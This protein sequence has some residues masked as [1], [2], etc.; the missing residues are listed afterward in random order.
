MFTRSAPYYD[1]VY[2][3]KGKRY[4][5][6]V[7]T[8]I[9]MMTAATGR[10]PSGS[11]L[12]VGCGTGEHL[13]H[14]R[15]SFE[16]EGLDRSAPMLDVARAKLPDVQLHQGD[17]TV[18]DLGRRFDVVTCLFASIGYLADRGALDVALATLVRH[19]AADGLLVIEPPLTRERLQPAA[20]AHL[21]VSTPTHTISRTVSA[22]HHDEMLAIS[23]D[24]AATPADTARVASR[25][26]ERH[27]IQL[28]PIALYVELL[29]KLGMQTTFDE[30]GPSG[31]GLLISGRN[32]LRLVQHPG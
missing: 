27:L 1:D 10:R 17:M 16:V 14:L 9:R 32:P 7:Q 4:A 30:A 8:L 31:T 29:S 25:F 2:A 5:D 24:Y 12:D 6:E 22:E 28:F 20:R 23:F 3:A 19:V 13:K 15:H 11:L 21:E 26:R 18:F